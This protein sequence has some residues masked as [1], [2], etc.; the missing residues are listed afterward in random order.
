[1]VLSY[2]LFELT[3]VTRVL[4]RCCLAYFPSVDKR[5]SCSTLMPC[6]LANT[7]RQRDIFTEWTTP[8]CG[9]GY[10]WEGEHVKCLHAP[11]YHPFCPSRAPIG[12]QGTLAA[13]PATATRQPA[14]PQN[15]PQPLSYVQPHTC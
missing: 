5:P 3:C 2:G 11:H 12:S 9:E 13:S 7:K 4:K 8:L 15:M 10:A 6:C 1:M 14:T